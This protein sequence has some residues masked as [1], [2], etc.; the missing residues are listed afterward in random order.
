MALPVELAKNLKVFLSTKAYPVS[1]QTGY[2]SALPPTVSIVWYSFKGHLS[3]NS[4]ELG[5]VCFVLST[6]K[7]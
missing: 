6:S 3:L 4:I 1:L 5:T 7:C 2:S